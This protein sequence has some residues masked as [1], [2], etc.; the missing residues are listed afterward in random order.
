MRTVAILGAIAVAVGGAVTAQSGGITFTD[1]TAASG[2]RFTHN[3]GRAGKK[4]LPE[5]LG[6][7]GAFF[8]F[9]ADGWVDVFLVNGKD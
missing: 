1:V 8:D 4:W 3:S 7:G 5:T 6:S 2:I 9:D